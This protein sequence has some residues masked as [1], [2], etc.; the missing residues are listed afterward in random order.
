[1]KQTCISCLVA[2]TLFANARADESPRLTVALQLSVESYDPR[3]PA[4]TLTCVVHNRSTEEIQLPAEYDGRTLIIYGGGKTHRH[5]S[6]LWRPNR[7]AKARLPLVTIGSGKRETVLEI[8]LKDIV[9][10]QDD[11]SREREWAWN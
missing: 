8:S 11:R 9:T 3:K 1:M 2:L 6:R 4:G 10:P 5:P 7:K